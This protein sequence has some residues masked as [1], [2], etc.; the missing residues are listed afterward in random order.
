MKFH[1][2]LSAHFLSGMLAGA[3]ALFLAASSSADESSRDPY[4]G[5]HMHRADSGTAWPKAAFGAWRLWDAGVAWP[6][7]QP[8]PG[9]WDF[10]RLDRYVAFGQ[11]F[12]VDILLPLGLSPA[13]AS[14]RPA[15]KSSYR[16]GWA[17][18]PA[19]IENWRLYVRTL[20]ERYR[21]RIRHYEVWNEMNDKG[22]YTG[23]V[24]KMVELTCEAH[25][26]LHEV[27]PD[28]RLIS[29]SL[30]G[31]GSEPEQF[32][33]FLRKGGKACVDV[34]GYHF[35]VPHRE[36]EEIVPLIGRVRAAMVRQGLSSLPLWNTESGWW[37]ENGDGTLQAG[38]DP[39]WR[40]VRLDE[41]AA[42]VARSL[43][44]GRAAGLER[45]YWYAWDNYILGLTEVS[46]GALKPAGVAYGT[47][48][49]WL[50]FATPKCKETRGTWVCALPPVG[51][52]TRRIVWQADG[53][54][55]SFA[56]LGEQ[57]LAVERLD[58]SRSPV[59][60]VPQAS[61]AVFYEPQLIVS[62]PGK[63]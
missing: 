62:A 55:A 17:A 16:P 30:I 44:L 33:N 60:S 19:D 50:S 57:V 20:A 63:P 36:P 9:Q 14:A 21:G 52:H 11:R 46:T 18:E 26:I 22:F 2:F 48:I 59:G 24:D 34:I 3:F 7:L 31:A 58:G 39:R 8:A 53:R 54:S 1:S 61:V 4:F 43:I 23:S 37:L 27:S 40:R 47:L 56:P 13:W 32:E 6:D 29:P 12:G 5:L 25:R 28:N 51:G 41:G 45:F 42:V 35:Y 38:A 10:T 15:E 49:R